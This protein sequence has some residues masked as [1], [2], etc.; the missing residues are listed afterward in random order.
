MLESVVSSYP[1][2]PKQARFESQKPKP[3]VS[4]HGRNPCPDSLPI[5]SSAYQPMGS[6]VGS[7]E[8][9]GDSNEDQKVYVALI[10]GR[11]CSCLF[12][13]ERT[14]QEIKQEAKQ[15]LG[16]PIRSL[17]GSSMKPVNEGRTLEEENVLPGTTLTAV[18]SS[19]GPASGGCKGSCKEA[20]K[21]CDIFE[22]AELGNVAAVSY[23]LWTEPGAAKKR[24]KRESGGWT[25][26]HKAA[27][28]GHA[29]VCQVLLAGGAE[30]EAR[31]D[32]GET[33]LLFAARR[34]PDTVAVR[35]LLEANASV[36]AKDHDG[37][38]PLHWARSNAKLLQILEQAEQA[39]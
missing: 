8:Q 15:K 23:F 7:T 6:A 35:V 4:S 11:T 13:P 3:F 24:M 20:E 38:T 1:A 34:A 21:F 29:Q 17:I 28:G 2:M 22:A 5:G 31:T 10:S 32:F 26:L 18:A 36:A 14:L 19:L 25:A 39:V 37:W 12:S 30:I 33:A 27:Y 9:P 16:V